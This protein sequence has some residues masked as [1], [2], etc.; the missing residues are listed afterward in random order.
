MIM[1]TNI[2]QPGRSQMTIW[3]MRI[4]R[5]IPKATN[6]DSEYVIFAFPLLQW[7]KNVPLCCVIRTLPALLH[8]VEI[9]SRTIQLPTGRR[10]STAYFLL[11]SQ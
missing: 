4:S 8:T 11:F 7:Y 2:V 10:Q 5:W 9:T 6:T 3:R 1:W